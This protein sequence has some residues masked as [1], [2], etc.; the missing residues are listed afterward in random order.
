M[1]KT[2]AVPSQSYIKSD[3]LTWGDITG[4]IAIS[5]DSHNGN[6]SLSFEN[7]CILA[8]ASSI[9][10]EQFKEINPE[11]ADLV[12]E[13]TNIILGN[14]K[15]DLVKLGNFVNLSMTTPNIIQGRKVSIRQLNSEPILVIPFSTENGSFVLEANL[16]N[17]LM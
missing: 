4:M 15:S 14:A 16:S 5:A 8:I 17:K 9:F 3:S 13:L 12:G 2:K 1:A 7:H 6:L 11:V 10:M